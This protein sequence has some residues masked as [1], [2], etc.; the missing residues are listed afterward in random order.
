MRKELTKEINDEA[1][2]LAKIY[3]N[4]ERHYNTNEDFVLKEIIPLSE[5]T[6]CVIYNKSPSEKQVCFF[7]VYVNALN[8]FWYSFIPTDSHILGMEAFGKYK[9]DIERYNFQK[10]FEVSKNDNT[11]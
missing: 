2:K 1:L 4:K 10:N 6:A 7:F 8:P 3:S 5:T 11:I 9:L